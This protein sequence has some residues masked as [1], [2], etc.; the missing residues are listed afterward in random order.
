MDSIPSFA[1][2]CIKHREY[3]FP[4][5]YVS[6]RFESTFNIGNHRPSTIIYVYTFALYDFLNYLF[7]RIFNTWENQEV[8]SK[9][10]HFF[11]TRYLFVSSS[12]SGSIWCLLIVK[13]PSG[14]QR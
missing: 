11:M 1:A 8:H 4:E 13:T 7:T 9:E 12:D 6:H 5:L 14:T 10:K 3:D 2:M